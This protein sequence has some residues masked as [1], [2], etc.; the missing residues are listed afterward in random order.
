[1]AITTY[2]IVCK[3]LTTNGER[4][5]HVGLVEEGKPTSHAQYKKTPKELNQL[6]R[7][8]HRCFFVNEKGNRVGVTELGDN[9]I[10]TEPDGIKHNNL[11][12]LRDCN[13]Q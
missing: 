6:I 8:G 2:Q 11:R 10:K 1:M 13:F 3:R 4:I 5:D 12:E 7:S 9:F